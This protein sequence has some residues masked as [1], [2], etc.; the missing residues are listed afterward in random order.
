MSE[1]TTENLVHIKFFLIMKPE[2]ITLAM[3]LCV[4]GKTQDQVV[5]KEIVHNFELLFCYFHSSVQFSKR[6]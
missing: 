5:L 2:A 1:F 4:N 3:T 6:M